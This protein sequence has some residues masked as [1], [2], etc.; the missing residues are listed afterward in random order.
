MKSF[1]PIISTAPEWL[2]LGD[3]VWFLPTIKK[4]SQIMGQKLDVIT[5]YPQLFMNNPHVNQIFDF[6]TF[7]INSQ[8][9]NNYFFRPYGDN[10]GLGLLWFTLNNRQA[11]ANGC[12][13]SLLPHEE[14][15]EFYP[16]GQQFNFLPPKYI[17]INAS[18][19]GAD[20]DLGKENWQKLVNIL[21]ENQI[22][23]V[24]EGPPEHTHN[25][26]IR[27][28]VNLIGKTSSLSETWHVINQ[29]TAFVSFDT[30]MYVFAGSTQTQIFLINTYFE[31]YWHRPCRKGSYDYKFSVIKG[32]CDEKC[33]SNLKYYITNNGFYQPHPQVCPLQIN[34]KCIPSVETI[35]QNIINYWKTI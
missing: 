10:D 16:Q 3:V 35:A 34:F 11:I 28:G 33:L 27:N 23:V 9:G 30:G 22:P 5:K 2:G 18:I 14:E 20:R 31:D 15:I 6:K 26:E 8:A 17:C 24:I 32:G 1:K 7:D 25:L 29:S 21:N 13:I 12:R 19:R 4:L